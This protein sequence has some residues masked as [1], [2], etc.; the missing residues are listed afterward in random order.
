M[1]V[2]PLFR[3]PPLTGTALAIRHGMTVRPVDASA[4]HSASRSGRASK[5][6]GVPARDPRNGDSDEHL[7]RKLCQVGGLNE[8]YTSGSRI[9]YH[10]Q[11]EDRGPVLDRI[12]EVM[13]RR[14]N[15]IVYCNSGQANARIIHSRDHDYPDVRTREHGRLIRQQIQKLAAEARTIIEEKEERRLGAIKLLIRK[16]HSSRSAND[17][18]ELDAAKTLHPRLFSRAWNE[19]KRERPRSKGAPPPKVPEAEPE[20]APQDVLYPLD[21]QAR[22]V[23]MEIERLV[24]ALGHDLRSLRVLGSVDDILLQTCRRIVTQATDSLTGRLPSQVAAKRLE[25]TRKHLLTTWRQVHSRLRSSQT[26]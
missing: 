18:K 20:T 14:V 15:V 9:P 24:F 22:E 7:D 21:P 6:E 2:P 4:A 12:L 17:K 16:Y 1:P 8:N 25:M 13:V 5:S 3:R 26:S 10:I 11:I 19:L 23:V